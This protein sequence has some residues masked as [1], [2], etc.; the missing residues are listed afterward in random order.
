VATG[1][2]GAGRAATVGKWRG[3]GHAVPGGIGG[4][5]T[6]VP[7]AEG[8]PLVTIAAL[9]AV[10]AVGD[11]VAEDGAV[12]A[13]PGPG[14]GAFPDPRHDG[15]TLGVEGANTTLV[16]V[17]TDAR[18]DKLGCRRWSET[19]HHGMARALRPSHTAFDGDAVVCLATGEVE[20]PLAER[21][22]PAVADVVAAA[23]RAAVA[24]G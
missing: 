8:G 10:N 18:L 17:A 2:V 20:L 23:I 13:G 9:A 5:S 19:A 4:A 11:V 6:Q 12:L 22:R 7:V 1:R 16:V 15:S 14:G 24:T 21:V 3:A